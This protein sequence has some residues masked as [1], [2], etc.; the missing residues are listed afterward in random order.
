MYIRTQCESDSPSPGFLLCE[1]YELSGDQRSRLRLLATDYL[2]L[3]R[4]G[5]ID[6]PS[7]YEYTLDTLPRTSIAPQSR[8]D[9]T[10]RFDTG[11]IG[12]LVVCFLLTIGIQYIQE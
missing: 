7:L 4:Q 3:E 12:N 1:L 2:G 6:M 5:Q 10:S 11:G 8:G 9:D